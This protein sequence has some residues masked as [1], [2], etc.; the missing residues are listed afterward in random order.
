MTKHVGDQPRDHGTARLREYTRQERESGTHPAVAALHS[1]PKDRSG[2]GRK[3]A[4]YA[5]IERGHTT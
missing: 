4:E 1:R 3:T 5:R 2:D